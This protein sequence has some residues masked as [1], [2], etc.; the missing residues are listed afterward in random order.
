LQKDLMRHYRAELIGKQDPFV[1]MSMGLDWAHDTEVHENAGASSTW[2]PDLKIPV[3]ASFVDS[4]PLK[5][6]VKESNGV[7]SDKL[8]GK[9]SVD[10][11]ALKAQPGTWV[12]VTGDLVDKDGNVAG[13]YSLTSRY[14]P[15][16]FVEPESEETAPAAEEAEKDAARV[17]AEEAEREAARVAAEEAEKEAARVAAEEAEREAARVAAEEAEREAARVAAEEAER[18]AARVAAEEAEREAARVAAEEAEREAARVAAEEAE[19][20]AARVADDGVGAIEDKT[21]T[22]EVCKISLWDLKNVGKFSVMC[23][24]CYYCRRT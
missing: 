2:T 15:T 5:L 16:G 13:H 12:D 22:V 4:N 7:S 8:I 9:A 10:A 23:A 20:E 1:S 3:T 24:R 19:R 17:A 6:K 21:G 11:G 14:V 18:E